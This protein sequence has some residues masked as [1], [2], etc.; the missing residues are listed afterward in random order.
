[1]VIG[2]YLTISKIFFVLRQV[3]CA[4]EKIQF[5]SNNNTTMKDTNKT[6]PWTE[7]FPYATKEIKQRLA[8]KIFNE[9]EEIPTDYFETVTYEPM[10]KL[11]KDEWASILGENLEQ[12]VFWYYIM[13]LR[14]LIIYYTFPRAVDDWW[15]LVEYLDAMGRFA[16]EFIEQN[17]K[18]WAEIFA[19]VIVYEEK[20]PYNP[21]KGIDDKRAKMSKMTKEEASKHFWVPI[22]ELNKL[23]DEKFNEG[24]K[25]ELDRIEDIPESFSNV[26]EKILQMFKNDLD[27]LQ[28]G[29]SPEEYT[30]EK[31]AEA[32]IV[33]YQVAL[34]MHPLYPIEPFFSVLY[35]DEKEEQS[36]ELPYR[37][38]VGWGYKFP[39]R[40]TDSENPLP[41]KLDMVYY[42][43]IENKC[44]SLQAPLPIDKF[45][46]LFSQKDD[47]G[48]P[49]YEDITFW[50]APFGK[51]AI[52]VQRKDTRQVQLIAWLEWKEEQ[53]PYED[54]LRGFHLVGG[55][56][57]EEFHENILKEYP[58][59]AE[60]LTKNGLPEKNLFDQFNEKYNTKIAIIFKDSPKEWFPVEQVK[61]SSAEL[62]YFNGENEQLTQNET[63]YSPRAK[64]KA[65]EINFND[66]KN[67]NSAYL[68]VPYQTALDNHA[69]HQIYEEAFGTDKNQS[70]QL[71][72]TFNGPSKPWTVTLSVQDKQLEIPMEEIRFRN[73]LESYR[74]PVYYQ[75]E[76]NWKGKMPEEKPQ[77]PEINKAEINNPNSDGEIP[78][79]HAIGTNNDE[80]VT[81]LLEAGADVNIISPQT[82]DTA[83]STASSMGYVGY[84]KQLI[85]AGADINQPEGQSCM[86]PLMEAARS[87][88]IEIVKLLVEAGADVNAKQFMYGQDIGYNALKYAHESGN[89]EVAQLLIDHGAE[90][91]VVQQQTANTAP[92][93][94]S[95]DQALMAGNVE[96][97]KEFLANGANPNTLIPGVGSALLFACTL[98]NAEIVQALVD[99]KADVNSLSNDTGFTPLMM[100]CQLGNKAIVEILVNAG[101]DVNIQ[102][103]MNGQPSGLNALKIAQNGGFN[104][105]AELLKQA[106]AKE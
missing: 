64:I 57:W 42:S 73:K 40:F 104:E 78:L 13:R 45:K 44:Y 100:A 15:I 51:V 34:T 22:E 35:L 1:M 88:N 2:L 105:I 39:T 29:K 50:A 43:I 66:G 96:K 91:P 31:K 4:H 41:L 56:N 97:V 38:D 72:F 30:A 9:K 18:E 53:V 103:Q 75:P 70:G 102:H 81:K 26:R 12:Q 32:G 84:V 62:T 5:L 95:L 17:P 93:T 28:S 14:M 27:M 20:Y 47:N 25:I 71:T 76:S 83:L 99:A 23:S 3:F 54:F 63:E 8:E 36:V 101:A 87:G 7:S 67:E 74:T 92:M 59:A 106:G 85:E 37:P 52:W 60:N 24:L 80:M 55:N 82:G 21:Q 61:I 58:Q 49:L 65:V 98:G 19:S 79:I 94:N 90:E 89:E 10:F 77:E 16:L 86:T 48:E 69:I 6:N 11:I 68:Y 33:N 46:E